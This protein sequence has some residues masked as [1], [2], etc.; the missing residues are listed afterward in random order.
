M[1]YY[2]IYNIISFMSY[3]TCIYMTCMLYMT[4]LNIKCI[5][6]NITLH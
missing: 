2:I 3:I 4:C 5:K 6:I 1:H